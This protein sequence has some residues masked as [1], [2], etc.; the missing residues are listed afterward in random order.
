MTTA[1]HLR[2]ATAL[3]ELARSIDELAGRGLDPGEP[4]S[5][6]ANGSS[7]SRWQS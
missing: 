4:Q 2:G 6:T 5:S 7:A 3:D 1:E